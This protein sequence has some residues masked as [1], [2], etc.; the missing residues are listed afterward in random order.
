LF[1][2]F[3]VA[4]V[5]ASLAAFLLVLAWVGV[6]GHLGPY[7]YAGLAA[8]SLLSAWQYFLIRGRDPDGCFRAFRLNNWVGA[9]VFAGTLAHFHFPAPF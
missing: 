7:F 4:A 9:A 1:G 3:D 5:M 6:S 2:R 8:A